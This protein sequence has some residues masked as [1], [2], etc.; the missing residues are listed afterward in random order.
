M[1]GR[2]WHRTCHARLPIFE[3]ILNLMTCEF[4]NCF[5]QCVQSMEQLADFLLDRVW[6]TVMIQQGTMVDWFAI[7]A[8]QLAGDTHN[9]AIFRHLMQHDRV[10][11]YH[12]IVAHFEWA[13]QFGTCTNQDVV[14]KGWVAFAFVLACTTKGHAMENGAVVTYLSRLP[15]HDPHAMI[16]K[17]AVANLGARM[18]L[19]S[20]PEPAA[21]G[22]PAGNVE[23]MVPEKPVGQAV[24]DQDMESWI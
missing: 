16:K 20:S 6:H 17:E 22:Y 24:E 23:K 9:G 14:A 7:V 15:D 1:F 11:P 19:D 8:D 10:C 12:G 2:R 4:G 21:L 18:N 3:W 13:Q 5:L